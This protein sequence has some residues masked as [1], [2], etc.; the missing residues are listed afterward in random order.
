MGVIGLFALVI[1]GMYGGFFTSTEAASIGAVGGFMFAIF[2]ARLGLR[3]LR[4]V[5]V[6]SVRTTSMVFAI[7]IGALIFSS[8]VNFTQLPQDLLAFVELFNLSPMIVIVAIRAIYIVLGTAFD[9]LSMVLL[10]IPMFF[11]LVI[12][13]GFD[14]I[15][16]GVLVVC[17]VEIG[18]ISPP[19][20]MNIFVINAM[21][22]DIP[23]ITVWRGFMPFFFADIVRLAILVTFPWISLFLPTL[24]FR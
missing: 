24:F 20:G 18:L 11:P 5:L 23:T 13:L 8:F 1:G 16:F 17:V 3:D 14:P 4:D 12:K 9:E 6:D 10:T 7:L 19:V 2:R 15:W 21:L 22:P